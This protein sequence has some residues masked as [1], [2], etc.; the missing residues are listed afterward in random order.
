MCSEN[1]M[2][3]IAWGY[4]VMCLERDAA[5]GYQGMVTKFLS[6]FP[7]S[8]LVT[9]VRFLYAKN[10]FDEH[11][12]SEASAQYENLDSS[13]LEREDLNEYT[14][15]KAYCDY[16]AGNFAEAFSGMETVSATKGS[17]YVTSARFFL[18]YMAY[19]SRD[20]E[21]AQSWF[22]YSVSDP[23]FAVLSKYYIIECRYYFEDYDYV[24]QNG[25]AALGCGLT[26]EH[27][28]RLSRLIAESYMILNEPDKAKEIYDSRLSTVKAATDKDHF[29]LGSMYYG[30]GDWQ[31]AAEEFLAMKDRSD[32]LGQSANYQLAHS[33]FNTHNKLGA[34]DAFKEAALASFD[35]EIT[36][37]AY[38]N[39]AKLSFDLNSDASVYKTYMEKYPDP[40]EIDHIYSYIAVAAL[41]AKNYNAALA[42]FDE[43]EELDDTMACNYMK[44][45]FLQAMDFRNAGAWK[46]AAERLKM[47]IHFGP[48]E[49]DMEELLTYYLADTQFRDGNYEASLKTYRDLYNH[50]ALSGTREEG[51]IMFGMAYSY[52]KNGDYPMAVRW[53]GKFLDTSPKLYGREAQVCIA[54]CKFLQ[55]NYT[56]AAEDYIAVAQKYPLKMDAYPYY[57]AG[58]CY[59]LASNPA[60]AAEVIENAGELSPKARYYD[61]TLMELGRSYTDLKRYS[62]AR[63]CFNKVVERN[64]LPLHVSRSLV[65]LGS[66]E[67]TVGNTAKALADFKKVVSDYPNTMSAEDALEAIEAIYK[68]QNDPRAY[69]AYIEQ[70]GL[71]GT[72][73]PAQRESM[74]FDAAEQIYLGGDMASAL[75]AFTR[76][77]NDYPEPMFAEKGWYYL[78]EIHR[79]TSNS[80]KA[81]EYYDKVRSAGDGPYVE[82]ALKNYAEISYSMQRYEPSY[83]AWKS[84]LARTRFNENR[85]LAVKG[86]IKSS[87]DGRMY[88]NVVSSASL[89]EREALATAADRREADFLKGKS[90]IMLSRRSEALETF[91]V[92]AEDP[93]DEFGAQS[94]FILI[95]DS[96]DRGDFNAVQSGTFA[97]SEKGG[98]QQYW[99][100]R[101][102]ILLGDSYAASGR[103]AQAKATYESIRDGY[104]PTSDA[105]DILETVKTRLEQLERK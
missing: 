81:L 93:S 34:L 10:L 88:E 100:A 75:T 56:E 76:Y 95:Q 36:K 44:A 72:K 82:L 8:T 51:L 32:S 24:A 103:R 79:R 57:Q 101:S 91:S 73:S 19:T 37:D 18:G 9:P 68:S 83:N 66:I 78:G 99:M 52:Y 41:R 23:R 3:D 55:N 54:D 2:D 86:M 38:L 102:F 17:P 50:N 89:M 33:L 35:P 74:I 64:T 97:F 16:V 104:T 84:L 1:S 5:P 4:M 39:Y 42:A 71:G 53:F 25:P 15:K 28:R 69:I 27:E 11:L 21:S 31:S 87:F 96:F 92:L 43:I 60:R 14:F 22:S 80:A 45:N 30:V 48:E 105:D 29:F 77:F 59:R 90:L 85:L 40:D 94:A 13:L 70:V 58:L 26:V 47:A 65:E 63:T 46:D 12:Y 7:Y 49:N 98:D 20:F 67:R 62:D 6:R 61:E